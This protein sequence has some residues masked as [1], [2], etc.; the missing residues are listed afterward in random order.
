MTE[1]E[2]RRLIL[3]AKQNCYRVSQ[4]RKEEN[5]SNNMEGMCPVTWDSMMCWDLTAAGTTARQT[6]PDYVNGFNTKEYV[7]KVCAE[8]GTWWVNANSTEWSNFNSCVK[9]S[10]DLSSHAT[11]GDHIRLLYTT[12]YSVS[13]V[14]LLVAVSIMVGCRRLHSKSNSLHINLFLAFILRAVVSFLKDTLFV[15][16]VGLAKDVRKGTDGVYEFVHDATHWEC[17]LLMTILVFSINACNM[18]ILSE[19][20]YLTRLLHRPLAAEGRGVRA[21]IILGWCK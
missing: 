15:A 3:L 1:L 11:H 16:N 19:A 17:K 6:C 21:Y 18:A 12:G 20:L 4:R 10:M 13:L 8:N 5:S 9:P 2:Q 7:T 14:F